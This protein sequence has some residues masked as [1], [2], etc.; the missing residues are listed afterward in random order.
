MK[1]V[2]KVYR[3]ENVDFNDFVRFYRYEIHRHEE[4]VHRAFPMNLGSKV[5]IAS[6]SKPNAYIL[7]AMQIF[8]C[9]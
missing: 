3:M 7:A 2:L 8:H 9:I 5:F 6:W 4:A 1:R